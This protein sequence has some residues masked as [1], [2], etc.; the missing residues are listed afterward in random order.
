VF[1]YQADALI[2]CWAMGATALLHLKRVS[3]ALLQKM[4]REDGLGPREDGG[5]YAARE[6][7]GPEDLA[8]AEQGEY[9]G[10]ILGRHE[11]HG[12]WFLDK[13]LLRYLVRNVLTVGQTL[14]EFGAFGGK[15]S[16]W[17][18]ETGVVEAFAFDG[19]P[20]VTEITDG[21]VREL[22]LAERF[23][24][25]RTFDWVL[26]L[27]VG[28]HL[29]PGTEDLL[30]DNIRRHARIGAIISWATP[31]YPSPYHPNTLTLEES[32]LL[33]KRHR[34]LVVTSPCRVL[35]ACMNTLL[36]HMCWIFLSRAV[37]LHCCVPVVRARVWHPGT[38]PDSQVPAGPGEDEGHSGRCRDL[39]AEAD[40]G[41]VLRGVVYDTHLCTDRFCLHVCMSTSATMHAMH[42]KCGHRWGLLPLAVRPVRVS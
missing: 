16:E 29:Q 37:V 5:W 39:L 21:R 4:G 9:P 2:D 42:F 41:R 13:P 32:T 15:Y 14:G 38:D 30:M 28:E 1:C 40:N 18:N 25:G 6:A 22:Q 24:L 23:D 12:T 8:A 35:P 31:D 36:H 27:E 17:L 33:I 3:G 11:F 34:L 26:C 7:L 10:I 20:N 19:I